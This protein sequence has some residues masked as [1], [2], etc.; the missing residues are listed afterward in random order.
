MNFK[1]RKLLCAAVCFSCASAALLAGM[2]EFKEWA[3]FAKWI[4]GLY[5]AGNVGEHVASK[6]NTTLAS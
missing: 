6:K 1:S 2:A 5:A 3:D 4:F